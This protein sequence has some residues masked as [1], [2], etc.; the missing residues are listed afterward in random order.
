MHELR[1]E[2]LDPIKMPLVTRLYKSHYPSGKAKSNEKTIVAY[3]N[4]TLIGVV[5]FRP[6]EQYQLLTGMLV[7]PEHRGKGVGH[8]LMK[9]C[10]HQVLDTDVYC[11]AYQHLESFYSQHGFTTIEAEAL[12]NNLNQLFNRYTRS[13]KCLIPMHFLPDKS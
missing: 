5:R 4:N 13:G 2:T 8:E 7:V 1:I 9:H 3:N 12:P 6:I 11:F 10:R